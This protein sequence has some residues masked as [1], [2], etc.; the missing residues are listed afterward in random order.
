MVIPGQIFLKIKNQ[1]ETI[2]GVFELALCHVSCPWVF[3][4][5]FYGFFYGFVH[6]KFR[7]DGP[8]S[9]LLD[10]SRHAI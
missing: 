6:H 2:F 9:L 5:V 8:I 3:Y 1:Q 10:L 7:P 4:G